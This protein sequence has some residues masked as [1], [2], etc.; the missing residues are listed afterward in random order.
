MKYPIL[1][2]TACVILFFGSCTEKETVVTKNNTPLDVHRVSTIKIQN[3]VNRTFIDIIGRN[4]TDEEMDSVVSDLEANN[5]SK[6]ARFK[7]INHIQSDSTFR[8]GDSSYQKVYYQRIYDMIKSKMVEGANDFEFQRSVNN[9]KFALKVARLE[10]DSVRVFKALN[11]IDRAS[12]VLKARDDYRYG[13][14]K[15]NEIFARCANNAV[16]DQINMNTFNFINATFDDLF[17]RFPSQQEFDIA[18]SIIQLNLTGFLFDSYA[19]NKSEY[20]TILTNSDEF[21]VGLINFAYN[22]L[23]SRNPNAQEVNN[24]YSKLRETD[25][26]QWLQATIASSDEYANF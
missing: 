12:A 24:L 5:L 21:Y 8:I 19:S 20:C 10:G 17:Y 1:S 18:Y 22:S 11:N 9:N 26:F 2:I 15:I 16:Y 14:I 7:F 4:P 6:E 25:D 3:Y 13:H 23:L